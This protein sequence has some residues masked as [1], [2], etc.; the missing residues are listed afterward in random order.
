MPPTLVE[1]VHHLVPLPPQVPMTSPAP[2][3]ILTML[4]DNVLPVQL[5]LLTST[6]PLNHVLTAQ[7]AHHTMLLLKAAKL[8]QL[9]LAPTLVTSMLPI[10]FPTHPSR[11][12]SKMDKLLPTGQLLLALLP[13]PTLMDNHASAALSY[14]T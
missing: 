10:G 4:M 3:T 14:L 11:T 8:P 5:R 7:L 9:Q 1:T 6:L 12:T 2:P 13:L